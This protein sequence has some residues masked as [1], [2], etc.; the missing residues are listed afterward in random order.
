MN[1]YLGKTMML[2]ASSFINMQL[3]S[4]DFKKDGI[5]YNILSVTNRT[6]EVSKNYNGSNYAYFEDEYYKG[7]LIIPDMVEYNGVNFTVT[8]IGERAFFNNYDITSISLPK[9][10][11]NY[12]GGGSWG[13]N[14]SLRRINVSTENPV[15][16]DIDGVLTN[17]IK[18]EIF[19]FPSNYTTECYAMPDYIKCFSDFRNCTFTSLILS[20]SINEIPSWG[21]SDC[22]ELV[23]LIIP[24]NVTFI[25]ELGVFSNKNLRKITLPQNLNI[26][27]SNGWKGP[28]ADCDNLLEIISYN[29]QPK[30]IN[31]NTFSKIVYITATLYVPAG[32]EE[33]Y[34][35]TKGWDNFISIKALNADAD[36]SMINCDSDTLKPEIYTMQ[37]VKLDCDVINLSSGIYIINGK[38]IAI[39]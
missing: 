32:C 18:D 30:S 31:D 11:V 16:S 39:D 37:G 4:Y 13:N 9:T 38:K 8:G 24:E 25:D 28:F 2:I 34:R 36:I 21:V 26:S 15:L 1:S 10:L 33:M 23:E 29:T 19:I 20:S 6:V 22:N 12:D 7:D 35:S 17:K 3:H 14:Y 27:I 5:A